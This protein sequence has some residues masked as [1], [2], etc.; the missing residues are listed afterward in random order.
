M[1]YIKREFAAYNVHIIKTDA[2]K[3]VTM[4]VNFLR[5]IKKEEITIRNFLGDILLQSNEGYQTKRLLSIEA[6]NLYNVNV[7]A[8]N[9]RIG[10]FNNLN[11]TLQFLNEKYT[12]KGMQDKSIKFFFDLL[13]NPNIKD[14]K[15][16]LKSFN[17]VKEGIKSDIKSIKDNMTKYALIKLLS[18]MGE[19]VAYSYQEYGYLD[20]LEEIT[21]DNLYEYYKDVLRSDKVDVFVVGDVDEEEIIEFIKNNFKIN[22]VKKDLGSPVIEHEKIR[23]RCSKI[24]EKENIVQSKLNIGCKLKGLNDF[25]RKYVMLL[26]NEILGGSTES[27]L[28]KNVREENS[29]AYYI[30]S[31]FKIYDNIMMIY[32]GINKKDYDKTLNLIKKEMSKM[33]KGNISD[34]EIENAKKNILSSY[35]TLA[36][37]PVKIIN[38]YYSK[39]LSNGEDLQ[40]KIDNINKVTKEDIIKV[41]NKIKFD[42]VYLMYGEDN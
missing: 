33:K 21:P 31:T 7:N 9:I 15:F 37:N 36:D 27:K 25:E 34:T 14:N 26:Y 19:N 5:K 35:D 28:F 12:E 1:E 17:I 41:A 16:D 18:N 24:N 40:E 22:T 2:F 30:S 42:T 6:G 38:L 8:N 3:T 4:E 11:F 32:S 39:E 23:S 13:F 29:L 20:D 10:N